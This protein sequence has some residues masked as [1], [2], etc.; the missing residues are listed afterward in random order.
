MGR[1]RSDAKQGFWPIRGG[2]G[3]FMTLAVGNGSIFRAA[4]HRL[5]SF[6]SLECWSFMDLTEN[7]FR[8]LFALGSK[9]EF[10]RVR[11]LRFENRYIV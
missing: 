5:L 4:V 2:G 9:N 3:G 7:V 11:S 6:R 10:V 8:I 1:F